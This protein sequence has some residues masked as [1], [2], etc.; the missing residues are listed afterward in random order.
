VLPVVIFVQIKVQ[1]H[2]T[3]ADTKNFLKQ[4]ITKKHILIRH[5]QGAWTCINTIVDQVYNII[6]ILKAVN[7]VL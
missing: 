6:L 2:S 3:S 5:T 7:R 1:C 4:N